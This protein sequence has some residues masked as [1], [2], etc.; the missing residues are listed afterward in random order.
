MATELT[1]AVD[2]WTAFAPRAAQGLLP[3]ARMR[4]PVRRRAV[5]VGAAVWLA[6]CGASA[7]AA[8]D[9]RLVDAARRGDGRAVQA[10]LDAGADADVR[11]ADGAAALHWAAHRD[12]AAMVR[13][14]VRAG[15][16]VDAANTYGVTPLSLAAANASAAMV[17]LLLAAGADPNAARESGETPLMRAAATGSVAAVEALLAAGA[18]VDAADPAG[19]QTPLMLAA[20]GR[21]ADVVAALIARGADVDARSRLGSTPLLFAARGGD[22][23]S[24]RR[25]VAAGAD[26]DA[27][28]PDG[29]RAL[30]VAT[31]R[32]HVPVAQFL[33]EAG[34]DPNAGPVARRRRAAAVP[35]AAAA[36]AG[37]EARAPDYTALHW[38]VGAWQTELA[39]P[40]GIAVER[41][42]EWEAIRGVPGDDK[43]VLV[44]TLLAFGADPNAPLRRIPP[45]FGYSQI[46]YEHNKQG[47]NVYGGATPLLLAA[48][49]GDAEVMRRLAAGGA[50]PTRTTDDGTTLLMVAAGLGRYEAENLV[51]EA[52][53]LAA[54]RTAL[55]LG[56]DVNAVN[57]VGNTAMHAAAHIKSEAIVQLLADRG[58]AIDAVNDRGDT[59][60]MV[61]DRFRAGSGNVTVRT[62]T[63]DLLRAL[64]AQESAA[65][66]PR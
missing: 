47:V 51:S 52:R 55:D 50:D 30:L 14:L 24:A 21:H 62:P 36:A 16:D 9:G 22:L 57:D 15:A 40:N 17:E 38:A 8:D 32:G 6:A 10:L 65:A 45:R 23:A 3:L 7:A 11:Q 19:G 27:A 26:V 2:H 44:E 54:V 41:D 39:G 25:L 43:R 4:R 63:G 64:G 46:S 18:E 12:D 42:P 48:M 37:D 35:D 31:V 53:T 13:Q 56:A 59:P 60:V 66:P 28:M 20:S 29:T 61:A 49:A 34:A 58:A 1:C 33:L 5:A